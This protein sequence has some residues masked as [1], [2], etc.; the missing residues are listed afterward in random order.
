MLIYCRYS[1]IEFRTD[2]FKN[3]KVVGEHPLMSVP[4]AELT[5][6]AVQWLAGSMSED[7]TRV[8]FVAL[9]KSTGLIEFRQAATPSHATCTKFMDILIRT[10]NWRLL[11]DDSKL[12]LPRFVVSPSTKYLENIAHY[13][14]SWEDAKETWRN[15]YNRA[16]GAKYKLDKLEKQEE[17]LARLIKSWTKR[18]EDY[19]WRLA[20]W[21][22]IAADVPRDLHE[23]W[24]ELFK[25]KRNDIYTAHTASLEELVE[26]MEDHLPH[27]SIY[28]TAVM[29]HLRNLLRK[30]KLQDFGLGME[31]TDEAGNTVLNPFKIVEDDIEQLN[32]NVII[33]QAPTVEPVRANYDSNVAYLK[34]K[35]A[36]ILAKSQLER[37]AAAEAKAQEEDSAAILDSIDAVIEEEVLTDE[38]Y[39]IATANLVARNKLE[40]I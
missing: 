19:A 35:A 30:N 20:K 40:G 1:G 3:F 7:E 16:M 4:T 37:I 18:S 24:T 14:T 26:H 39:D 8:L 2:D 36:W 38:L 17:G 32:R 13:L 12:Q 31:D 22:L 15:N 11:V 27:G 28:A 23:Y 29:D 9:L 21:A 25:L 6:K 5:S 33:S 10:V 34:A